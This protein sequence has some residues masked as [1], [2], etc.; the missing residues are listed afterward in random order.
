[1]CPG[2]PLAHHWYWGKGNPVGVAPHLVEFGYW[3]S[4]NFV[5]LD[6]YLNSTDLPS[7]PTGASGSINA[8]PGGCRTSTRTAALPTRL[9]AASPLGLR[10]GLHIC[11]FQK[12]RII[13][14]PDHIGDRARV[15]ARL[16][17]SHVLQGEEPT[18]LLEL[19]LLGSRPDHRGRSRSCLRMGKSHFQFYTDKRRHL[20]ETGKSHFQVLNIN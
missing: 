4:M 13:T 3:A 12:T 1:M 19:G 17:V 9:R 2:L 8:S 11:I 14:I 15:D 5:G 6:V 18:K 20:R 7:I 10:L 16:V